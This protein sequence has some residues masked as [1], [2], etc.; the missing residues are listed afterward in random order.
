MT[1]TTQA[2][3]LHA[4]LRSIIDSRNRYADIARDQLARG[5][6]T[7]LGAQ[8]AFDAGSRAHRWKERTQTVLASAEA[9]VREARDAKDAALRTLSQPSAKDTNGQLLFE[10]QTSRVWARQQRILDALPPVQRT[11]RALDMLRNATEPVE[12]AALM[13][14]LPSYLTAATE[15]RDPQKLIDGV[16][17][18]TVPEVQESAALLA[19]AERL[20][21]IVR[22]NVQVVEG[23]L[24]NVQPLPR[25]FETQFIDP[26]PI[27]ARTAAEFKGALDAAP[28]IGSDTVATTTVTTSGAA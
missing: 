28:T 1:T 19:E 13:A 21:I 4:E 11:V 17:L 22:R 10:M 12:R 26:E 8:D 14:E 27:V 15:T 7:D 25:H 24:E 23:T 20:Q 18:K 9:A 16:I 2:R 5:L 6:L 3:E